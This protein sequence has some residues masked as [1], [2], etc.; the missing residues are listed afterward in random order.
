MKP[1]HVLLFLLYAASIASAFSWFGYNN[2]VDRRD[3]FETD[4]QCSAHV[5]PPR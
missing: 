5:S 2:A 4:A 3:L 1:I